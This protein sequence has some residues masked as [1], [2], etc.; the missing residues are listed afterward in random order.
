MPKACLMPREKESHRLV[1]CQGSIQLIT[2]L[3]AMESRLRDSRLARCRDTLVIYDL[4]APQGQAR[5][6]ADYVRRAAERL[7]HWDRIV[8]LDGERLDALTGAWREGRFEEACAGVRD[9]V[10]Q[11]MVDEIYL[12]RSFQPSN[13]LFMR[14][15]R[16]AWR[17]CYG[18]AIGVY[19]DEAYL[20]PGSRPSR[21]PVEAE[22]RPSASL[23]RKL[24]SVAGSAKRWLLNGSH[25]ATVKSPLQ[26]D[27]GYFLLPDFLGMTPPMPV[28][29]IGPQGFRERFGAVGEQVDPD[30]LHQCRRRL[31]RKNPVVLLT[32][33]FSEAGRLTPEAE[34]AAYREFLLEQSLPTNPVLFVKPHPRDRQE[35]I[36][37]L[38]EAIRD[39]CPAVVLDQLPLFFVPFESLFSALFEEV[40]KEGRDLQVY[41]FS[42]S[43][44]SLEALYQIRC[45]IGFGERLVR[46]HFYPE[47]VDLRLGHEADLV[48]AG[49]R[50][51]REFSG[52]LPCGSH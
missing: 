1:T 20:L 25:S 13:E 40:R 37:A 24:R 22:P 35:K 43:S 27:V 30:L 51:R 14:C 44:L 15:F 52:S 48:A 18:D 2:A 46:K 7:W 6:F 19:F 41:C 11:D 23:A 38:V 49:K 31:G 8:F 36:R 12:C 45:G 21:Q 39:L 33:N 9:A 5:P 29:Q 4:W 47:W 10:G 17:V 42:T 28:V 32:S 50:I 26:F 3:A 34:V 16:D